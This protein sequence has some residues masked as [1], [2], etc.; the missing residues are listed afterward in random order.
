MMDLEE[1]LRD[2]TPGLLRFCRGLTGSIG[3]GHEVAQESLC[4][5]VRYWRR[6]GPPDSAAAFVFTVA[7]RQAYK[8][9]FRLRRHSP[10]EMEVDLPAVTESP[11]AYHEHRQDLGLALKTLKKLPRKYRQALLLAITETLSVA[12]GAAVLGIS[13]SAF[14]MRVHRGRLLLKKRLQGEP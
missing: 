12:Q 3:E 2:L 14:K 5:L 7:R 1:T 6:Q 4:A 11:E 8:H 13:P 10:L 9:F